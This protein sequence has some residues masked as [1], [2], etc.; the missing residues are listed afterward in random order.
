MILMAIC[1]SKYCF[2]FVDIGGYGRDNDAAIVSQSEMY[3]AFASNELGVPT[4]EASS[5][6]RLPYVLVDLSNK[7]VANAP[8]QCGKFYFKS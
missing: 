3:Q 4:T 8:K 6:T 2:T 5:G 1:D 7:D